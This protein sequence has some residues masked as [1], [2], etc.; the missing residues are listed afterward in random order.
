MSKMPD[1]ARTDVAVTS[2]IPLNETE[3]V[4]RITI[5]YKDIFT[6]VL[7][8]KT[9]R[10]AVLFDTATY[11]TDV[12]E[13]IVPALRALN[14]SPEDLKYVILS[15]NHKDHAGGLPRIMEHYPKAVI[16]SRSALIKEKFSQ[17]AILCPEDGQPLLDVLRIV[18]IPGHTADACGVYDTRN[19][20]LLCGDSLQCFGIFGSGNWACNITLPAEHFAA[21]SKL[22]RLDIRTI[23]TAHDY[24][25][26]GFMAKGKDAVRDYI[27]SC[28][29]PLAII[30]ELISAPYALDD[31]AICAFF[32][33]EGYPHLS[34]SVPAAIRQALEEGMIY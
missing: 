34:P 22:D 28:R 7:I 19:G 18:T 27:E 26:Y 5:P 14:V 25:P 17:Y 15:H 24:H 20:A 6:T 16:V 11:D 30:T 29:R 12:D 1:T 2:L 31:A 3:S 10:G 9:D 4:T 21:L 32:D 33:S 8:L 23:L 13:Y